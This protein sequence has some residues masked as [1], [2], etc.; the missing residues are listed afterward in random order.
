[1]PAPAL[2]MAAEIGFFHAAF[3]F[4]QPVISVTIW[5]T[6][7]I[8]CFL[9]Y[10]LLQKAPR[11]LRWLLPVLCMIEL[12][13]CEIGCMLTSGWDVFIWVVAYGYG[14][15]ALLGILLAQLIHKLKHNK[16]SVS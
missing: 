8:S 2:L 4:G 6:L 15:I 9:Q 13:V 16:K 1:M 3:N 12:V 11:P 10:M 14:V 7:L 5:L